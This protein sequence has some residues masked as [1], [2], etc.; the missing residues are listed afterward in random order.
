MA[1]ELKINV[2]ANSS[3]VT[4]CET[5]CSYDA[6]TNPTGWGTPNPETADAV[7]AT[8]YVT[9][10]SSDVVTD[11]FDLSTYFPDSAGLCIAYE[12]NEFQ[13]TEGSTSIVDGIWTFEYE[14]VVTEGEE[15]VPYT[16]T[17]KFLFDHG[18][19]CCIAKRTARID[20]TS[21][22]PKYI[23]ETYALKMLH[24]QARNAFCAQQY[25]KAERI[26]NYLKTVCDCCCSD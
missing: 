14:V 17:C 24:E 12:A 25:D 4:F 10:P 20:I 22:D 13:D 23:E 11:T 2:T 26:I 3:R 19:R 9:Q 21:C 5:T 16:T 15:E 18:I 1:L 6:S 7:S 8:L